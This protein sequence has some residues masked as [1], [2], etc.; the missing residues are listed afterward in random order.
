MARIRTIKPEFWTD[1]KI[2]I[3]K[4]DERLLFIGMWNLADDQGVV[5]S[6]PAYLKGQ[7]F[8][9]DEDLRIASMNNW[10]SS[11]MKAQLII[12]FTFNGEGYYLIRSFN[13][14]QL[15]NRP[16][17]PKFPYEL[18]DSLTPHGVLTEPSQPEG[19]GKERKGKEEKIAIEIVFPFD[20]EKFRAAWKKWIDYRSDASKPYKSQL[21]EQ[22]ALNQLAEFNEAFAI[23]LIDKSISRGWQGLIF[24]TTQ[25]DFQNF[26][27]DKPKYESCLSEE[28]KKW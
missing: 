15:I 14:H 10:L 1:E 5:K 7:L 17:K 20:S 19:K 26:K 18:L 4:R 24:E 27:K 21:S 13:E 3:L 9:Y 8:S 12:P 22:A 28:D 2:G 23:V 11:L 16:S 6:N 25:K